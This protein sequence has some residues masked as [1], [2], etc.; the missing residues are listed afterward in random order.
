MTIDRQ[1]FLGDL[2][3]ALD[4]I[5]SKK[6]DHQSQ[7]GD[8][9]GFEFIDIPATPQKL[10]KNKEL[11][12][13][14]KP[15]EPPEPKKGLAAEDK[16][17]PRDSSI[18]IIDYKLTH[19]KAP[20]ASIK[21]LPK[22]SPWPRY[23]QRPLIPLPPLFNALS[24][25]GILIELLGVQRPE[26]DVAIMEVVDLLARGEPLQKLPREAIQTLS[27][28]CHVLVDFSLGM[29]PF[30]RD[31]EQ[32]IASIHKVVGEEHTQ[33]FTFV[34]SPLNGVLTTDLVDIEYEPPK[35]GASVL[36]ITDLGAVSL[37]GILPEARAQDWFKL[38][39]MVHNANCA[40]AILN[41]YIRK[42]WLPQLAGRLPI[43]LWDRQ[44]KASDARQSRLKTVK[45]Q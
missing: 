20:P 16:A 11:S 41:P 36:A 28:G 40:F 43:V 32:L 29:Q 12:K 17:P 4:W 14:Q 38:A 27:Q 26:G 25:R 9:L 23:T 45:F 10:D 24:E 39:S 15:E 1:I 31:T 34:D 35:N 3:R 22:V 21:S 37:P 5:G 30:R 7:I 19:K 33:V 8:L 44:I 18:E 42:R 6:Q 13:A 2:V